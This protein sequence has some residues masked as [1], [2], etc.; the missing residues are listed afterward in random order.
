MSLGIGKETVTGSWAW[1]NP[2]KIPTVKEGTTGVEAVFTPTNQ[3]KFSS[4]TKNITL[5]IAKK[6]NTISMSDFSLTYG[7]KSSLSLADSG[8]ETSAVTYT[9]SDSTIASING[10]TLSAVGVG[11][12]TITAKKAATDN[13]AESETTAKVTI[14]KLDLSAGDLNKPTSSSI[15][16]GDPLS[17]STLTGGT[18]STLSLAIGNITVDGTWAW[19]NPDSKPSVSEGPTGLSIFFTPTKSDLFNGCSSSLAVDVANAENTTPLTTVLTVKEKDDTSITLNEISVEGETIEYKKVGDVSYVDTPVFGS[20]EEN[21]SY[22]FVYRYKAKTNYNA[23]DDSVAYSFSTKAK[24]LPASD[25]KA[26]YRDSCITGLVSG[27]SYSVDGTTMQSDTDGKISIQPSLFDADI[28]IVHLPNDPDN[29]VN[30][31][32]ITIAYI[33]PGACPT[34]YSVV[35]TPTSDGKVSLTGLSVNEEYSTDGGASYTKIDNTTLSFA[36]KSSLIIRFQS[37][38]EAPAS[39]STAAITLPDVLAMPDSAYDTGIISGLDEG[40]SYRIVTDEGATNVLTASDLSNEGGIITYR[41]SFEGRKIVSLTRL[42]STSETNCLE[43]VPEVTSDYYILIQNGV[44]ATSYTSDE[45]NGVISSLKKNTSYKLTDST[46]SVYSITS[47]GNGDISL[48]TDYSI[49]GKTI[50]SI[51]E[52]AVATYSV[53]S[54]PQTVSY[55]FPDP[56]GVKKAYQDEILEKLKEQ[57]DTETN[58]NVIKIIDETIATIEGKSLTEGSIAEFKLAVDDIYVDNDNHVDFQKT[59]DDATAKIEALKRTCEDEKLDKIIAEGLI[60]V[61]SMEYPS[62]SIADIDEAYNE[63]YTKVDVRLYGIEKMSLVSKEHKAFVDNN[64][65]SESS[66]N[67]LQRIEN[68]YTDKIDNATT[69]EEINTYV[70]KAYKAYSE[71]ETGIPESPCFYHWI[72]IVGIIIFALFFALYFLVL[73]RK[74]YDAIS[75]GVSISYAGFLLIMSIFSGCTICH[76]SL[77]VGY[78]IL[79]LSALAWGYKRNEKK[80]EAKA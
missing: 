41:H 57:K 29:F 46:G 72:T 12:A 59:K 13:Y 73:E 30:S 67:E 20:L 14:S 10:S 15:T 56:V 76:I 39:L 18:S 1:S 45:D 9:S 16:Y 48:D 2:N 71:V 60:E 6:A 62:S 23:S 22:S 64:E 54:D 5:T 40:A 25:A 52:S 58:P 74:H 36:P 47:D 75:I 55:V 66:L 33:A 68:F 21:T 31:D 3:T 44:P 78:F 69:K 35:Q 8:N 28:T 42:P 65:Y 27:D 61:G 79:A 77:C 26:N 24:M 51:V 70:S 7:E 34:G 80:E 43:S 4:V 17:S 37:T 32:S 63:V 50:V 11:E 38:V 49:A 19:A 53:D